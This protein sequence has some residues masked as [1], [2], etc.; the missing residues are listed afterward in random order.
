MR[1]GR[2]QVKSIEC[3]DVSWK[4]AQKVEERVVLSSRTLKWLLY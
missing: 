1:S 3:D 4:G 2:G